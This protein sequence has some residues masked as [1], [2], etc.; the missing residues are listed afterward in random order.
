[1]QAKEAWT[2]VTILADS[3]DADEKLSDADAA[4][5]WSN[6]AAA[7]MDLDQ[8]D[9]ALQAYS[10]ACK[11]Q[12]DDVANWLNLAVAAQAAGQCGQAIVACRQA[13]KLA[14][15]SDDVYFRLG[16]ALLAGYHAG[17][18][19]ELLGQALDAWRESLRL[20]PAQPDLAKL[21]ARYTQAYELTGQATS[22]T[23]RP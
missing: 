17:N 12:G 10:Q 5:A 19:R 1:M 11:R 4:F 3:S 6:L 15:D 13:Q 8:A 2:K 9:Q 22:S 21:L 18:K 7:C 23:S 16:N 20:N 14:P